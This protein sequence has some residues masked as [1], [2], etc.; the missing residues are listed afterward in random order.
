MPAGVGPE[1]ALVEASLLSSGEAVWLAPNTANKAIHEA[2]P[3]TAAEGSH[4]APDSRRMKETLFHRC[5]QVRDGEGFPLHQT[6]AASAGK[7]QLDSEIKAT[8]P[9]AEREEVERLGR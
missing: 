1:V 6:D 2:A 4:I 5:H 8:P 3:R 7:C 9:C